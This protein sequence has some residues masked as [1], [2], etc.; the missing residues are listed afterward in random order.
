[1]QLRI[2]AV[3]LSIKASGIPKV[4]PSAVRATGLMCAEAGQGLP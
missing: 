3:Q 4:S 1:M 2:L